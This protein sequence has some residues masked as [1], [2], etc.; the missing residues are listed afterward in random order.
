MDTQHISQYFRSHRISSARSDDRSFAVLY[1]HTRHAL[2]TA[3]I[4]FMRV[5]TVDS[6][7]ATTRHTTLR[8][9]AMMRSFR[10]LW[11]M[12]LIGKQQ[13]A[14]SEEDAHTK[15]IVFKLKDD[16]DSPA[17]A[18]HQLSTAAGLLGVKRVHG[19]G[20]RF[21]E[22][23]IQHG[24]H[25]WYRG[26]TDGL[27]SKAL[28]VVQSHTSMVSKASTVPRVKFASRPDDPRYS[29][30]RHH[31]ALEMESA[32]AITSGAANVVVAIIDSGVD[33]DHPDLRRIVCS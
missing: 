1:V 10:W 2:R 11:L 8:V 19:H 7:A 16:I 21:E 33:M 22:R 3:A 31:Q 13:V 26:K 24:L 12:M 32:W 23:H 9:R 6:L 20:G 15:E 27:T 14:A 17:E 18:V 28:K 25:L 30:Q 4:P 5:I 29:S